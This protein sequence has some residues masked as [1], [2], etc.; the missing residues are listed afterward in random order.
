MVEGP[1]GGKLLP[2][3]MVYRKQRMKGTGMHRNAPLQVSLL[4]VHLTP[5]PTSKRQARL[6]NSWVCWWV[7]Y[8]QALPKASLKNTSD[9][10]K[11]AT[12][13]K[14]IHSDLKG[15]TD[16]GC[17]SSEKCGAG[18]RRGRCCWVAVARYFVL[19]KKCFWFDW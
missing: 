17:W 11:M 4:V 9:F 15:I 12:N 6:L 16:I 19:L 14:P 10:G 8:P 13:P 7:H 18:D 2:C 5:D 1:S 3:V